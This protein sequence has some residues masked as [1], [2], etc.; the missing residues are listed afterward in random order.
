MST[1]SQTGHIQKTLAAV[2]VIALAA[3]VILI[4]STNDA[5]IAVP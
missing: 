1:K 4:T 2:T 5:T 3:G